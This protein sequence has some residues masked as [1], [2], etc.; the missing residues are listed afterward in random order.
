MTGSLN[1]A[2]VMMSVNCHEFIYPQEFGART[3]VA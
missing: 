2:L 1:F 3:R